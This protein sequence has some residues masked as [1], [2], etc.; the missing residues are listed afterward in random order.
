MTKTNRKS[1]RRV[2]GW[3]RSK[4]FR[5]ILII[6]LLV[7]AGILFYFW[8]KGR[9]FVLGIIIIL[10]AA[11]GLEASNNDIDLGKF[12]QT[13]SW[14]ESKIQRDAEG[15]LIMG[16][17]C[18]PQQTYNYNCS[19]FRY[20]EEAQEVYEKCAKNGLDVHGLDRDKN[21]IACQSLPSRETWLRKQNK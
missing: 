1:S 9:L 7:L 12:M 18:D 13:G 15:N 19:D 17:M 6:V 20:Q 4:K 5:L 11:L 16:A 2:S 10:L 3:R 14:S 8:Q 21:G